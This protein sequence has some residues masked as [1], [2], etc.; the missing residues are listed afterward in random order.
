M[1]RKGSFK[2]PRTEQSTHT[3]HDMIKL[4]VLEHLKNASAGLRS[5]SPASSL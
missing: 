2:D 3:G 4:S 1:L 5:P